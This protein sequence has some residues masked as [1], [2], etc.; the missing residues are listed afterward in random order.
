[1]TT[2]NINLK[3]GTGASKQVF[4]PNTTSANVADIARN[5]ALSASLQSIIERNALGY[6]A[7][8]TKICPEDNTVVLGS[9][10]ALTCDSFLCR[11]VNFQAISEPTKGEKVRCLAK[12]R[13]HQTERPATIEM[14]DEGLVKVKLDEAVKGVSP[15]QS[16]VFYDEDGHVVGGGLIVR[17]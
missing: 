4:A 14:T 16:A 15:G 7:F 13:Y 11:E 1:M 17:D 2:K 12:A 3:K 6:P 5:Q 9:E 10:E 8:V